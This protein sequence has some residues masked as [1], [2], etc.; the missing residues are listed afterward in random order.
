VELITTEA[1]LK[2]V[3]NKGVWLSG[4]KALPQIITTKI[5]L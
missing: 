3:I 2:N 4:L 1:K 5:F